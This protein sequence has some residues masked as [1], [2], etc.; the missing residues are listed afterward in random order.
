MR[1]A[2]I[3]CGY[4]GTFRVEGDCPQCVTKV[5]KRDVTKVTKV[6]KPRHLDAGEQQVMSR[7]LRKSTGR[8]RVGDQAMTAAERKRRQRARAKRCAVCGEVG[9]H[10]QWCCDN[11]PLA[12]H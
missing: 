6:T 3:R 11:N 5:T 1:S 2:M 9:K 8:P 12:T 7:A 10:K 4:C